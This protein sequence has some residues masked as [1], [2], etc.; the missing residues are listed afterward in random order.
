MTSSSCFR[1][2]YKGSSKVHFKNKEHM[3]ALCCEIK[4]DVTLILGTTMHAQNRDDKQGSVYTRKDADNHKERIKESILNPNAIPFKFNERE[5]S[6]LNEWNPCCPSIR[7]DVSTNNYSTC[8]LN[9]IDGKSIVLNNASQLSNTAHPGGTNINAYAA[10]FVPQNLDKIILNKALDN[11]SGGNHFNESHNLSTHDGLF[12]KNPKQDDVLAILK[13]LRVKNHNSIIVGNLNI[14]S[15]PNKFDAL[16]TII[17]GNID[18]FVITETKLDDT[19]ETVQFCMD[20]YNEPFRLDKSRNSG[21]ILIYV[22]EG[23]PTR[24]LNVYTFPFDIQGVCI[25]LNF[26]KAKWLLCGIYHPPSQNDK[27]FFECLGKALDVYSDKYDKFLITGDFN[28][29]I[30]ESNH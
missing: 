15:I 27:Y 21:G 16:K 11:F 4:E 17:P 19:F 24:M 8:L 23:I 29:Q 18:I 30:G 10:P 28:I 7:I 12:E 2:K 14:N 20:G 26:R 22:R 25:E 6:V 3:K 1:K 13:D 5:Q 9:P